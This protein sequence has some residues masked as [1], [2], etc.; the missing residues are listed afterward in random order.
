MYAGALQQL[1]RWRTYADRPGSATAAVLERSI[2]K[3]LAK[4][5]AEVEQLRLQWWEPRQAMS[6][7]IVAAEGITEPGARVR[8]LVELDSFRESRLEALDDGLRRLG[9]EGPTEAQRANNAAFR[10]CA[11]FKE[12]LSAADAKVRNELQLVANRKAVATELGVSIA[13][14]DGWRRRCPGVG[15]KP[16]KGS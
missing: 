12:K 2:R 8:R 14:L 4:R 13:T 16:A 15:W 1:E 11:D 5:E 9:Q 7:R 3:R 6:A 10:D